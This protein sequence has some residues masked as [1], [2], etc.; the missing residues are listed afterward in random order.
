MFVENVLSNISY[1]TYLIYTKMCV[2]IYIYTIHVRQKRMIEYVQYIIHNIENFIVQ[3][4][5]DSQ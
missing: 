1:T 2:Y 5:M 3:N 4:T